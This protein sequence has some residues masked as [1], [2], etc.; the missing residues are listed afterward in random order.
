MF[1]IVHDVLSL[2]ILHGLAD[3]HLSLEQRGSEMTSLVAYHVETTEC[4]VAYRDCRAQSREKYSRKE[5]TGQTQET[6]R[7]RQARRVA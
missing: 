4:R 6:N 5:K 2:V 7:H 1:K 3:R